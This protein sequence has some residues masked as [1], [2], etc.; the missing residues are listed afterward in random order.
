VGDTNGF[1]ITQEEGQLT[2]RGA[3]LSG[4]DIFL[5]NAEGVFSGKHQL[6][7]CHSFRKQ[8]LFLGSPEVIDSL[9]RGE[10]TV[11]SL[12]N[13]HVLDCG[14]EGLLETMQE[15]KKRGILTVGAGE[16]AGEACKPLMLGIKGFHI[17]VLAYLEIDPGVL[18]YIGM[19]PDW[20]SAGKNKGGVASWNL[21]NGQK[22]IAETRKEADIIVV[23]VHMHHTRFNWTEKP[24]AASILFVKNIL[25]AGAD[26]VLGSGAHFPQGIIKNEKGV[27]L[28]SL[29][30]FLF[31]PDYEMAEKARNSLLADFM[32]SSDRSEVA[33]V[34]LRLDISGRPRVAS[35]DEAGDILNGIARLSDQLGTKLEIRGEKGYLETKRMPKK[36]SRT[37]GIGN[38][39]Q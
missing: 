26:I 17:A 34:P 9:P 14:Q 20:L 2:G 22:Q 32:I 13:N 6:K 24:R 37:T 8:T 28:L 15:L 10:I 29:G 7:D 35:G 1:N 5:F 3:L 27:A 30:N 25:D 12:A 36:S 21:C 4:R 31:R 18:A 16:N 23:F 19:D 11:A 39:R 38:S 33:I